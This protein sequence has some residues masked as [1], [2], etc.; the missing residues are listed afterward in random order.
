MRHAKSWRKNQSGDDAL[1]RPFETSTT[2]TNLTRTIFLRTLLLPFFSSSAEDRHYKLETFFN[3]RRATDCSIIATIIIFL[4]VNCPQF[5]QPSLSF[6]LFVSEF[7]FL[8]DSLL[9]MQPLS[10]DTAS[11]SLIDAPLA[12][13]LFYNSNTYDT[14]GNVV[15]AVIGDFQSPLLPLTFDSLSTD[16]P[17]SLTLEAHTVNYWAFVLIFFPL[18]TIFGNVLVVVSVYREKSLHNVTNYFV[19]SLA[20][21]DITVAALVMPFAIYLEVSERHARDG[22]S[23]HL[24]DR[25]AARSFS[26]IRRIVYMAE[27]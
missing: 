2:I 6:L 7:F 9:V 15:A 19:V 14:I 20:I 10:N 4:F 16:A 24:T 23:Q 5:Q 1:D 22:R 8:H 12:A 21:S 27:L 26:I 11:W 18:F 3:I 25:Q 17:Q 13:P